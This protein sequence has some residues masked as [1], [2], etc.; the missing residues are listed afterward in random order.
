MP[1]IVTH[2]RI[3]FEL[4]KLFHYPESFLVGNLAPD[5]GFK[6]ANGI[7]NPPKTITHFKVSAPVDGFTIGD[8]IFYERYFLN[9]P[10]GTLPD[11]PGF[12]EG[13]FCHLLTDNL[14]L[15]SISRP[16]MQNRLKLEMPAIAATYL[17]NNPDIDLKIS[18][19]LTIPLEIERFLPYEYI[20]R[21]VA[22]VN[23]MLL[24]VSCA[25]DA[26]P[27]CSQTDE[28]L[29]NTFVAFSHDV[30]KTIIDEMRNTSQPLLQPVSVLP[31][32]E[33]ICIRLWEHHFDGHG[34]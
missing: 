13:Y 29:V 12:L 17:H 6:L 18:M 31:R 9:R 8:G 4:T 25:I 27:V 15:W 21:K 26:R 19:P 1:D 32:F 3:G 20:R 14:W 5:A 28:W 34:G 30:F 2:L 7:Y 22:A 11:T 10:D 23:K 33:P 16:P 24:E